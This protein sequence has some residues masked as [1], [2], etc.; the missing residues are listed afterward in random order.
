M[1]NIEDLFYTRLLPL[2]IYVVVASSLFTL[3]QPPPKHATHVVLDTIIFSDG[4]R[5]KVSDATAAVCPG[6]GMCG[7]GLSIP[8]GSLFEAHLVTR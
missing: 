2:L 7:S 5:L 1:P 4:K 3:L 6:S 8:A